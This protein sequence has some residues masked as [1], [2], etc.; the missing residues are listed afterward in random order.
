MDNVTERLQDFWATCDFMENYP[1]GCDDN[2]FVGWSKDMYSGGMLV[3]RLTK[4]TT[5]YAITLLPWVPWLG[6]WANETYYN[7]KY[8]QWSF[9]A[10]KAYEILESEGALCNGAGSSFPKEYSIEEL[11]EKLADD[12]SIFLMP[13]WPLF[14]KDDMDDEMSDDGEDNMEEDV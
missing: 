6:P 5:P 7:H 1:D 8:H 13:A 4:P 2:P 10:S 14:P 11:G 9:A 12:H 3:L